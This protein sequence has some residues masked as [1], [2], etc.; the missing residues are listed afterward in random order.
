M[1]NEP[2]II[3]PLMWKQ[4]DQIVARLKTSKFLACK[5]LERETSKGISSTSRK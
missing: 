5:P 1:D 3:F 4:Y 2:M